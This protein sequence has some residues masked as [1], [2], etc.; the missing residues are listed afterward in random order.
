MQP[1]SGNQHGPAIPVISGVYDVLESGCDVDSPPKM[2]GVVALHYVFTPVAE[3]A[4]SEQKSQ[5]AVCQ[6]FLVALGD[7]IC[8]KRDAGAIVLAMP[9]CAIRPDPAGERLLY[10]RVGKRLRLAVIPAKAG[11]RR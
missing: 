4:I 6:I 8:D 5:P 2:R 3:R 9:P 10:L 1:E 7:R 11:K